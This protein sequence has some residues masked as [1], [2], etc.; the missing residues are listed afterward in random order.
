MTVIWD[1]PNTIPEYRIAVTENIPYPMIGLKLGKG[2]DFFLHLDIDNKV[3]ALGTTLHPLVE[4]EML[5]S[6]EMFDFPNNA[7]AKKYLYA[8]CEIEVVW[9]VR[10]RWRGEMIPPVPIIYLV[11]CCPNELEEVL[12]DLKREVL[13]DNNMIE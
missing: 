6:R 5:L 11:M 12:E 4:I 9:F 8:G 2:S 7:F 3:E 1:T 10:M 13:Q